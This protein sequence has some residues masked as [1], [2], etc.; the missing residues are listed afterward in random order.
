MTLVESRLRTSL[1]AV[2]VPILAGGLALAGL[3]AWTASGRA[4]SPPHVGVTRAYVYQ[5]FGS[6]PETAAFFTL[7]NDG[8]S[9]DRLVRV[10]SPDTTE[11][12]ALSEHRMTS[13]NGA[14]RQSVDSI[15]VPARD[16]LVMKPH[17]N[18]VT[19]RPKTPWRPGEVVSFTL[20]FAHGKPLRV[21]AAVV[22]PGTEQNR[23]FRP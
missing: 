13:S 8:G 9:A 14:Y 2:G 10:T 5:S 7:T 16:G 6:T 4:G 18:D 19:V 22:R 1:T 15:L 23:P 20:H 17:G 3:G 11:P 21:D 12:P